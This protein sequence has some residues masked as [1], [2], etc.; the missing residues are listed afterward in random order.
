M[1]CRGALLLTLAALEPCSTQAADAALEAAILNGYRRYH[2]TCSHCHGPDGRG[3]SFA[4][5]L[6]ETQLPFPRFEAIVR[7]GVASGTSVMQGFAD[8]PNLA[9][10][11]GDIYA[12]LRARAEGVI[13]RGRPVFGE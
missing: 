2:G 4:P 10:Y 6:I 3:G 1:W 8:D 11:I 5:S 9:P 12:D 13:G 7:D